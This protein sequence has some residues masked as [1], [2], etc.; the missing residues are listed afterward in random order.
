[1]LSDVTSSACEGEKNAFAAFGDNRDGKKGK[2]QIVV[3]LLCDEE[4]KP[5]S[6][7]VFPG[8]T[9][10]PQPVAAHLRKVTKRFG[11]GPVV[12]GGDR[13]MRKRPH[14]AA[15]RHQ[16]FHDIPALTKPHIVSLL[17]TGVLHLGLFPEEVTDVIPSEG[18]RSIVRRNPIRAQAVHTSREE[19]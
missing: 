16:G 19:K 13:G 12:F 3:G 11:G 7:E 4:G 9:Q 10:D 18:V 6:I 8:N 1:L 5:L 2:R 15:L 14:I 17:K